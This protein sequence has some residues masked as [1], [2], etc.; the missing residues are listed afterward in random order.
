MFCG[1]H[2]GDIAS[3]V[4][5]GRGVLLVGTIVLFVHDYKSEVVMRQK[6]GGAGAEQDVCRVFVPAGFPVSADCAHHILSF[7]SRQP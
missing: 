3:V 1:K 2:Q 6:E 7:R 4:A 5:R